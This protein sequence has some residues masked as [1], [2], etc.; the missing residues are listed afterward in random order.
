[1]PPACYITACVCCNTLRMHE[2]EHE[3]VDGAV[4]ETRDITGNACM[5]GDVYICKAVCAC[6][7]H[8]WRSQPGQRS[9]LGPTVTGASTMSPTQRH[10]AL[11]SVKLTRE[12]ETYC[13]RRTCTTMLGEFGSMA[14][15]EV[16]ARRADRIP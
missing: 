11:T 16:C 8:S 7:A 9:R 6:V 4:K 13:E 1:M 15:G 3:A 14:V 10:G 5:I 12:C 2:L